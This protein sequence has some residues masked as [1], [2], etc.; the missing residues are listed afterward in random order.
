MTEIEQ[1][2]AVLVERVSH[3]TAINPHMAAA[4]CAGEARALAQDNGSVWADLTEDER[5]AYIQAAR[6][7]GGL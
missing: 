1:R 4:L 7:I 3:F 5:A 6:T 2:Q